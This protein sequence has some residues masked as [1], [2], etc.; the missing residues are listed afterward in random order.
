[1][2][3]P[4]TQVPPPTAKPATTPADPKPSLAPGSA[5][6]AAQSASTPET[7][8][9]VPGW[10]SELATHLGEPQP[11]K[12]PAEDKPAAK[13]QPESPG[14]PKGPEKGSPKPQDKPGTPGEGRKAKL[15]P[16]ELLNVNGVDAV[17]LP[18]DVISTLS[19]LDARDLRL[20]SAKLAKGYR[21]LAAAKAKLEKDLEIAKAPREDPERKAEK[22]NFEGLRKRYEDVEKELRHANYT[23]S[24]EYK[25]KFEKPFNDALSD[26]YA[27]IRELTVETD[28][29]TRAATEKDFDNLLG[30]PLSEAIKQAKEQFGHAS[31]EVLSY[32]RKLNDIR[33]SAAKEVE[34]YKTEGQKLEQERL[35]QQ[36]KQRETINNVW[37]RVNEELPKKFSELFG[38]VEGDD[39]GNA[40]LKQ[41]YAEVDK[42]HDPNIGL[43]ER[44]GRQ[45]AIRHRAAAF[46]R[47]VWRRK[48]AEQE[49]LELRKTIEDYENSAPAKGD[50]DG[51]PPP[52]L[53]DE[54]D[55]NLAI[56]R[57]AV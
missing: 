32:R 43:E 56:D 5:N 29:G 34:R 39:D 10:E 30:L 20:Q 4:S 48:K 44:I 8:A 45:A 53:D 31:D 15:D 13:P 22:E 54:S 7:S 38:E 26:A 47:E 28:E 55:P 14:A 27:T 24:P 1:M 3:T 21:A 52:A 51:A 35:V 50:K 18:E 17:E 23:K 49:I 19:K 25:E 41:G 42:A 33:R 36:E 37:K 6:A 46:T 11:E 16:D 40:K 12:A 2:A 57:I 9:D